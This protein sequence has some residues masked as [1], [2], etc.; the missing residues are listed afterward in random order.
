MTENKTK[1]PGIAVLVAFAIL[2]GISIWLMGLLN[3]GAGGRLMPEGEL[4]PVINNFL[5]SKNFFTNCF[6]YMV[7]CLPFVFGFGLGMRKNWARIGYM[8]CCLVGISLVLI[9]LVKASGESD[10]RVVALVY[11]IMYSLPIWYLNRANIK[12]QF[13]KESKLS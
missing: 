4:R 12:S 11:L 7:V 3:G 8:M 2:S 6:F 10:G 1:T 9:Y 13:K 5:V